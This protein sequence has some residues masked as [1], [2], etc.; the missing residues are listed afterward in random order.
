MG[1]YF[2]Q[3]TGRGARKTLGDTTRAPKIDKIK[4]VAVKF[5]LDFGDAEW[6]QAMYPK[7]SHNMAIKQFLI[8]YKDG[9]K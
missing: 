4:N 1:K 8:D 3:K 6:F 5:T 9:E 7:K 2:V